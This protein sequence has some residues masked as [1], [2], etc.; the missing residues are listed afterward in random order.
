MTLS[1]AAKGA[2][3]KPQYLARRER[4]GGPPPTYVR[5]RRLATM[6]R[7]DMVVFL[8]TDATPGNQDERRGRSRRLIAPA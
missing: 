2:G 4:S 8:G 7:V 1:T 3:I 5:A 6:Y